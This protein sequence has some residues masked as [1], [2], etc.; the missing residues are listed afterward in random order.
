VE[1]LGYDELQGLWRRGG[2]LGL[3]SQ[4]AYGGCQ[5]LAGVLIVVYAEKFFGHS[6]LGLPG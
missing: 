5:Q 2:R 6:G 1:V 3:I 4:L